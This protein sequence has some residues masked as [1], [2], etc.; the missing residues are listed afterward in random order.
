MLQEATDEVVLPGKKYIHALL[1]LTQRFIHG[2]A[3]V[4]HNM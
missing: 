3:Q 4:A 1:L 2:L